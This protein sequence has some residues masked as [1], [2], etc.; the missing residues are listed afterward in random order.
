[1]KRIDKK[2]KVLKANDMIADRIRSCFDANGVLALNIIG[3]PGAG[4]TALLERTLE[5]LPSDT[6]VTVFTGDIATDND[7]V[8]LKKYGHP[9]KQI[10]TEGACHLDARMV[11]RYVCPTCLS[12]EAGCTPLFDLLFIENVGNLVC[13]SSF[14]LG[15]EAKIVVLS[16]TEGDD[17]P[18]KYPSTFMRA[19][20]VILNKCDLLPHIS[21]SV[22]QFNE[23]VQKVHPGVKVIE[24]A[25]TTGDGVDDWLAWLD[26][27]MLMKSAEKAR[28]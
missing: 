20:L 24:M 2:E 21:F 17:K 23:N 27:R 25:C 1:M 6:A 16:A 10:C 22:D 7:A 3:S 18:L 13:P 19:E 26:T 4:K 15:E 9:V 8:R 12:V 28:G 14:D 5:R 11:A